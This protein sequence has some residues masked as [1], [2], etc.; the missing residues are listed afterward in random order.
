MLLSQEINSNSV[1]VQKL[2]QINSITLSSDD[3]LQQMQS[4][5]KRIKSLEV[6]NRVILG[7]FIG[8][9]AATVTIGA[10]FAI[11]SAPIIAG[12]IVGGVLAILALAALGVTLYKCR[13]RVEAG[14]RYAAEKTIEGVKYI[15]GQ[16]K[17]SAVRTKDSVKEAVSSME[18]AAREGT[19]SA[20][21]AMGYKLGD[22][23]ASMSNLDSIPYSIGLQNST[24]IFKTE[25]KTRN[26]NTIK[27]MFIKEVF[28][29]KAS[30]SSV[31]VKKVFSEL[32][33]KILEK[34]YSVDGQQSFKEKQLISQL[35]YQAGFVSKLNSRKLQNLLTQDNNNLYEIFSEYHD[36]IKRI[37]KERKTEHKLLEGINGTAKSHGE[38]RRDST[39]SSLSRSNLFSSI[40]ADGTVNGTAELLNS[41]KHRK[42]QSSSR[43]LKWLSWNKGSKAPEEATNIEYQ[44]LPVSDIPAREIG[45][46]AFYGTP[47]PAEDADKIATVNPNLFRSN[48]SNS[49]NDSSVLVP[50][51][52]P[53]VSKGLSLSSLSSDG[54]MGSGLFMLEK[55]SLFPE[56]LAKA[57]ASLKSTGFLDKLM[58]QQPS[59]SA[60][61]VEDTGED[62]KRDKPTTKFSQP[63]AEKPDVEVLY[64]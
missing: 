22:L 6:T 56:D 40:G 59:T 41:G 58:G 23:G 36:E 53:Q 15:G 52:L 20:L 32:K 62:F 25:E 38:S 14:F 60:I 39:Q 55:Q 44:V 1:E 63:K 31:L 19:S 49:L 21:K 7:L 13:A 4:L 18:Q 51:A 48:L 12:S 9:L 47:L 61:A 64:L 37:V 27:E 3:L 50:V 8:T 57:R 26:F 28:G 54:G 45:K 16:I 42:V 11:A 34:A 2:Q 24:V 5:E 30:D 46:S 33:G 29:D 10:G 17:D 43:F 35:G